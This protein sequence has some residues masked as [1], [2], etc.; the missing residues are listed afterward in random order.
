MGAL[1]TLLAL[2]SPSNM[3]A[4]N[5]PY[6]DKRKAAIMGGSADFEP[7]DLE[8]HQAQDAMGG[9]Y[10][11]DMIRDSGMQSLRRTLGLQDI[12]HRQDMER[13]TAPE[14][15]K[16]EYGVREAEATGR[17][18]GDRLRFSAD[19]TAQ[20]QDDNQKAIMDRLNLTIG[21]AGARQEDQQAFKEAHPTGVN[22]TVNPALYAA[23][24]KAQAGYD[25]TMSSLA[26][27]M[28]QDGGRQGLTSALTA[29]LDKK[30]TLRDVGEVAT[31]I[32]KNKIPGK[33]IDEVI[34][35]SHEPGLA[36]LDP[37]ERKYLAL[38]LGLE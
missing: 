18:A 23:V 28:N 14:M 1:E 32:T 16:G 30:G 7:S 4:T 31:H 9:V 24:Q 29:L 11:R 3:T 26:R 13:V 38:T 36:Q 8:L 10:S 22:T 34:N 5:D 21:A 19:A 37:Y 17:A 12:K 27:R 2:K 35:N 15:I 25:S 6:A 33:S 20:R